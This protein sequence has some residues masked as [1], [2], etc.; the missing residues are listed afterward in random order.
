[1]VSNPRNDQ[2][3]HPRGYP[4]LANFIS[5]DRD[6]FVF[7]RFNNL[8]ARNLL[9]LQDELIELE[10]KLNAID[11]AELKG[12]GQRELW[13]LHS[14]REDNNLDRRKLMAEMGQKLRAYRLLH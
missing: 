10:E 13:N 6:F 14:R 9:Y 12:G 5:S 1:M 7:R 2:H 8:A 4:S 11:L 3:P